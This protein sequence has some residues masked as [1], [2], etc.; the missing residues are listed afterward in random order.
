[1]LAHRGADVRDL[2][3]GAR[4]L[5]R[6]AGRLGEHALVAGEREFRAGDRVVCRGNDPAL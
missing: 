4:A 1:M 2:N 5:L 3:D 6:E